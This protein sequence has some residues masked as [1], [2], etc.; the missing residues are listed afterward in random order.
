MSAYTVHL[1]IH[2]YLVCVSFFMSIF[3]TPTDPQDE[4]K[5]PLSLSEIKLEVGEAER[6]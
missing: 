3:V 1:H 6:G 2:N 4:E 5:Q